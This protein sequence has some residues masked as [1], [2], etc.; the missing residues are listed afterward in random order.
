MTP[1]V[2]LLIASFLTLS[3]CAALALGAT[4]GPTFSSRVRLDNQRIV[5]IYLGPYYDN[6]AP[7]SAYQASPQGTL[8]EFQISYQSPE[9]YRTLVRLTWRKFIRV[10]PP[11]TRRP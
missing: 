1:R 4:V 11:D 6:F 3:L 8:R 2:L 5:V 9:L 7:E 10:R